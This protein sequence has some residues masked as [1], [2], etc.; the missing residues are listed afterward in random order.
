[1]EGFLAVSAAPN[2]WD[3]M[4]YHLSRAAGW[5]QHGSLGRFDAHTE[6][7]NI[8]PP[9]AEI[10]ILFTFVSAHADRFAA[11][12]QL[13]AELALLVGIFGIAPRLRLRRSSAGVCVP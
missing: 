2:N 3:G 12:P 4:T 1:F 8:F 7:E 9:N 13:V 10:Q 6:R 5:L 11:L